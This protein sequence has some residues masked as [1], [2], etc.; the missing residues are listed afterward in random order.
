VS[1]SLAVSLNHIYRLDDGAI[2]QYLRVSPS[3]IVAP[4]ESPPEPAVQLA[5][6]RTTL[7][8]LSDTGRI[9]RRLIATNARWSL[10]QSP[11]GVTWL[12]TSDEYLQALATNVLHRPYS[13][14]VFGLLASAPVATRL[15]QIDH[16]ETML[17][18]LTE[19]GRIL[20]R[21][22]AGGWHEYP[23]LGAVR[24][25]VAGLDMVYARTANGD[26]YRSLSYG[27]SGWQALGIDGALALA[28]PAD[29]A[30]EL[31]IATDEGNRVVTPLAWHGDNVVRAWV[32]EDWVS[33]D[34]VVTAEA[35]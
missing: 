34:W 11:G 1:T 17:H 24:E 23:K 13:G 25:V 2:T 31:Y 33:S 6:S 18:A 26:V 15:V 8:A 28:V 12:S 4:L 21:L 5:C 22:F 30:D 9:Y 10:M 20:V 19:D 14:Q 16:D 7:Y 32:T 35:A 29:H 3:T 27:S